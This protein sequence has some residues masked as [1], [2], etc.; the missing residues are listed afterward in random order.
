MKKFVAILM[1]LTMIM[2]LSMVAFAS[3]PEPGEGQGDADQQRIGKTSLNVAIQEGQDEYET[4]EGIRAEWSGGLRVRDW[5]D[6]Y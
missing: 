4:Y 5:F 3:E 6:S 1:T 2:T